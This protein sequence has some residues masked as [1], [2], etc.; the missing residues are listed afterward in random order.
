MYV[1]VHACMYVSIVLNYVY[2]LTCPLSL[3]LSVAYVGFVQSMYTA[4][5][6]NLSATV[7]VEVKQGSLGIPVDLSLTTHDDSAQGI[8]MYVHVYNVILLYSSNV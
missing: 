5:E 7:C 6:R 8:H 2:T 4:S 1:H 3:S